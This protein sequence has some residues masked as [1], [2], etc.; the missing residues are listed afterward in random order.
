MCQDLADIMIRKREGAVCQRD[1]IYLLL[2]GDDSRLNFLQREV[3]HCFSCGVRKVG[4]MC[5]K[6]CQQLSRDDKTDIFIDHCL[7][8]DIKRNAMVRH[9][10]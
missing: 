8:K 3:I 1:S 4:Q 9:S 7:K 6:I 2:K 5:A 10:D